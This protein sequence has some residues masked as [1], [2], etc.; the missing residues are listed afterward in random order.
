MHLGNW[1]LAGF[2]CLTDRE[3]VSVRAPPFGG[4]NCCEHRRNEAVPRALPV[5][6]RPQNSCRKEKQT[7][8]AKLGHHR[9]PTDNV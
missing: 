3:S 5:D 4:R 6:S 2:L 9:Q 7:V 8:S 1:H